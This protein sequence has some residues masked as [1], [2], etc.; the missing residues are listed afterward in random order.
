MQDVPFTYYLYHKPTQRKYYGVRYKK[1]CHPSDLWNKYFSSSRVVKL[2]IEKYGLDSFEFEVRK[3]FSNKEDAIEW[4][5]QVLKR[6]GVVGKGEWINASVGK[7]SPANGRVYSEETKKKMSN[8][9]SGEKNGF[10]GKNHTASARQ[11]ISEGN[12]GKTQSD[13]MR[14]KLSEKKKGQPFSGYGGNAAEVIAKRSKTNTGKKR[15]VEQRERMRQA[16]LNRK[17]AQCHK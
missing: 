4:E 10:F 17:K 13:E 15:T 14:K 2:L 8:S 6:I 9:Q 11:R 7:S 16:Q 12:L 1:G 5:H 3:T